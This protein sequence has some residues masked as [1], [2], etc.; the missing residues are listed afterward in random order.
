[1][2]HLKENTLN[3]DKYKDWLENQKKIGG[4][5]IDNSSLET[6]TYIKNI[7]YTHSDGSI[8][9][10]E[11]E[12]DHSPLYQEDDDGIHL[13][14]KFYEDIVNVIVYGGYDLQDVVFNYDLSY[15]DLST[16]IL[17]DIREIFENAI[18]FEFIEERENLDRR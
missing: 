1:M 13:I 5:K 15:D 11:L 9:I 6:I 18:E 8:G 4:K 10:G 16:D 14:E 12:A 17:K 2:L 3:T 7:I